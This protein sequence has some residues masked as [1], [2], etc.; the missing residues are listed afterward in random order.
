MKIKPR[1]GW[2]RADLIPDASKDE[3]LRLRGEIDSLNEDLRIARNRSAPEGIEDLAQGAETTSITVELPSG[4]L[5]LD[6]R[7]DRLMRAILPR[8]L[9]G[10]APP[11]AIAEAIASLVLREAAARE[12]PV[13]TDRFSRHAVIG[14]SDY[15]KVMNQMVALGL[16]EARSDPTNLLATRWCATPYGVQIGTRLLA[17]KRGPSETNGTTS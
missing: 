2:V 7:W 12:L 1:V 5:R 9:G 15:G 6:V 16:V 11:E 4:N 10:G 13:A 17:I 8:T 14:G 3:L